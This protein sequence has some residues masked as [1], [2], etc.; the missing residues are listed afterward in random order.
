VGDLVSRLLE[1]ITA[2]E[3]KAHAAIEFGSGGDG[4]WRVRGEHIDGSAAGIGFGFLPADREFIVDN[5]PSSVLRRCAA[6]RRVLER[7]SPSADHLG[8][9]LCSFC[10]DA[11]HME[12]PCEDFADL[13]DRYGL[14]VTE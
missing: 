7:H 5:D 13:V 9:L 6:D 11:G 8:R 14:E 12:W 1:A 2:K 3:E 4:P 10:S